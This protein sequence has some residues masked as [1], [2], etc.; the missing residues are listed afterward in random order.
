M[1]LLR[2]RLVPL[3]L[4]S[5]SL[6]AATLPGFTVETV[7]RA[8]DF[9]SSLAT[10]S[11][12]T[13]YFTTTN[14]WI[15]RADGAA[16]PLQAT[17]IA[18]VATHAEGNGG[19]LGMALLDDHTAAV[20]YTTFAGGP[21]SDL[22]LDDVVSQID[23]A[24]GAETVLRSFACDIEFRERGASSEHHGGNLTVAA[25]GSIFVGI[26]DYNSHIIAQKPE[27]NAGKIWRVT[28]DG[29]ATQ[30][31]LGVRNPFDLAWDPELGRIVLSDNGPTDGDEINIVD[32]GAN[33]G[34]PKT[35]GHEAPLDGA[36]APSYVFPRTVAPTG[37]ARLDGANPL[38]PHGY[39]VGAFV[40]RA[41]YY[42]PTPSTAP[43]AILEGFSEPVIDVIQAANG[44]IYF[45]TAGAGGT[46]I[47]RLHVPLRGD[48]NGD[49]F[50]DSRDVLPLLRELAD[51][52]GA[53]HAAIRAQEGDNAGSWAC[54]ANQDGVIDLTDLQTLGTLLGARRRAV[55][56]P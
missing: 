19:L 45:A 3:L 1:T 49:G 44:D 18:S 35:F 54:D 27:W 46:A 7:L 29:Q 38:I 50:T 4:V 5:L 48:C 20:H 47:H 16:A 9:V 41:I 43:V 51:G 25:D 17:R 13:L 32:I 56:N 21:A 39:L 6:S 31:A 23:L 55:R 40:T 33:L 22:V 12:G 10:D 30:W 8:P 37:L 52:D 36:I 2:F 24:T 53:G 34:W 26:G 14:G 11:Q 28:Q 42:F 15:H